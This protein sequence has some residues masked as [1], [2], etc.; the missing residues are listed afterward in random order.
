MV[1]DR[2]SI[3][4]FLYPYVFYG[5]PPASA[6]AEQRLILQQR[7]ARS[8]TCCIIK[9]ASCGSDHLDL[10]RYIAHRTNFRSELHCEP[11]WNLTIHL[12][13]YKISLLSMPRS[14]NRNVTST[15]GLP[16]LK[17]P[18]EQR[19]R[20]TAE[21][22]VFEPFESDKRLKDPPPSRVEAMN[23]REPA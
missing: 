9:P 7:C 21:M 15:D 3:P 23:R 13:R 14:Q 17:I 10:K 19:E 6:I 18:S 4:V 22:T 8:T 20:L 2:V 12:R 5:G 16:C 1:T 11:T